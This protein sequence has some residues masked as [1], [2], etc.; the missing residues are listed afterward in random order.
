LCECGDEEEEVEEEFELVVHYFG[1]EGK[2]V[3]LCV[4]DE[5]VLVINGGD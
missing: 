3:V 5:V 4:L 1:Y 2:D